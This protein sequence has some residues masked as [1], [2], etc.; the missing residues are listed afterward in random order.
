MSYDNLDGEN[1]LT[2]L[3]FEVRLP[4]KVSTSGIKIYKKRYLSL[5]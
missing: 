5:H 3:K 4:R 2:T 1:D